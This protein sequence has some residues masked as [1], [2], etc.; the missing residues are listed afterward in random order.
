MHARAD[1]DERGARAAPMRP[2]IVPADGGVVEVLAQDDE[3]VAG[4]AGQGVAGAE[5]SR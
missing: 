1:K 2:A 3:L 4:E 5:R